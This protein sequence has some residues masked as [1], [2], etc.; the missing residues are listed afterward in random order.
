MTSLLSST[1]GPVLNGQRAL[2]QS[3]IQRIQRTL[4]RY[5]IYGKLFR[6][7]VCDEEEFFFILA[8]FENEQLAVIYEHLTDSI[9]PG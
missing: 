3:E 2:S 9:S 7:E 1:V 5:E 8:S 4:H 6:M